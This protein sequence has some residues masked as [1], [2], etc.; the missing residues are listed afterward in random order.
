MLILFLNAWLW[1]IYIDHTISYVLIKKIIILFNVVLYK[2]HCRMNKRFKHV[3]ILIYDNM[4]PYM[5]INH[6]PNVKQTTSGRGPTLVLIWKIWLMNRKINLNHPKYHSIW[7][8]SLDVH[9]EP[10]TTQ[11][12]I[13]METPLNHIQWALKWSAQNHTHYNN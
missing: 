7:L 9:V 3:I 10:P 4:S 11:V 2:I 6:I 13:P 1:I 8:S 5:A 12:T